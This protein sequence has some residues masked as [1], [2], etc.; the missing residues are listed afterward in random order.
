MTLRLPVVRKKIQLEADKQQ[1]DA[2]LKIRSGEVQTLQKEYEAINST[3]MQL[4]RQKGYCYSSLDYEYH[5]AMFPREQMKLS[6]IISTMFSI[7]SQHTHK[8]IY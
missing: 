6:L 5:I 3:T 2:D 4:E 8:Q 7:Y 1:K